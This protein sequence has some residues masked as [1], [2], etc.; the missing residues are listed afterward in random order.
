MTSEKEPILKNLFMN[1]DKFVNYVCVIISIMTLIA[2]IIP[3]VLTYN[4]GDLLTTLLATAIIINLIFLLASSMCIIVEEY[5][6][7]KLSTTISDNKHMN[8]KCRYVIIDYNVVY[9]SNGICWIKTDF[10]AL[11]LEEDFL[12]QKIS[13][14]ARSGNKGNKNRESYII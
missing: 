13:W 14:E 11:N 10:H 5:A 1:Y 7:E 12:N 6:F 3:T 8:K 4:G 2:L 9:V